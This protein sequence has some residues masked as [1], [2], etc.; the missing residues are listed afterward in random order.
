MFLNTLF[1]SWFQHKCSH[2]VVWCLASGSNRQ[3]A[4]PVSSCL[5]CG[6]MGERKIFSLTHYPLQQVRGLGRNNELALPFT[7]HRDAD[8]A[9]CL[10]S[11]LVPDFLSR[12]SVSQPCGFESRRAGLICPLPTTTIKKEDPHLSRDKQ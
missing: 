5:S 12:A 3:L 4:Y 6:G 11:V 2:V 10:G 7:T 9:P 1:L 8:P